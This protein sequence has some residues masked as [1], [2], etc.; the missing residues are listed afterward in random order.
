M[1]EWIKAKMQI[2]FFKKRISTDPYG[3]NDN[4]EGFK[5]VMETHAG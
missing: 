4:P 3:F 2:D 5:S 1:N